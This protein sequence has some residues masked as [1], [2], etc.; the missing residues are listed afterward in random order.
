MR[1]L[2]ICVLLLVALVTPAQQVINV[3]NDETRLA[4]STFN[5]LSGAP[6]ISVKYVNLVEGSPYFKDEW[7]ASVLVSETGREYKDVKVRLDL[8]DNHI[9]FQDDKGTDMI[10]T[11]PIKEVVLTDAMSNNYKFVH[12]SRLPAS[13]II[14]DEGWFMW[15]CSGSAS[16]YKFHDKR[17]K[18]F[19]PY[20]SATIELTIKT[21]ERYLVSYNNALLEIKKIKDAPSVLAN[22]KAE[23]EEYLKTKDDKALSMDDRITALIDYYN[24]LFTGEK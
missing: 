9:H 12:S 22:K 16:L 19:T 17:V 6:F 14:K 20:N 23:L 11:S 13:S 18:E 7:L 24:S 21:T 2:F 15:L 10:T 4:Q 3:A 8:V 1:L 5:L